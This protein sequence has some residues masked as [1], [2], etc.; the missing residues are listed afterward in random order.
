MSSGLVGTTL[1][2]KFQI[3]KPLASGAAGDVY[4]AMHLGLGTRVAVKVLRPGIE[5]TAGIRRKRFLREARVAARLRSDHVVRVYD[6]VAPEEGPTYIVMELLR[7]ETL[8]DRLKRGGRFAPT[9]AVDFVLQAARP[10]A[11]MHDEGIVHR[12][13]KP[14]NL[15]LARDVDGKERIKL[16][17]FGVAAFQQPV[18]RAE[19]S[20]TFSQAVL[21][22]PKYM[23]PEQV[24]ASSQVDARADVWALG[25]MLYRAAAGVAPFRGE[26]F[27]ALA[28][29]ILHH[30]P[31]PAS[32][33]VP[34]I[35]N[36]LDVLIAR[37]LERDRDARCP[38]VADI[39]KG[40]DQVKRDCG[41]DDEAIARAVDLDRGVAS[42]AVPAGAPAPTRGS[43]V[44]SRPVYQGVVEAPPRSKARLA[45][46][47]GLATVGLATAAY[48]AF[49]RAGTATATAPATSAPV[50]AAPATGSTGAPALRDASAST[51]AAPVGEA[52]L[53]DAIGSGDVQ[54]QS[55]AVDAL[56]LVASPKAAPLLYVAL[57]G[58][59]ELRVKAARALA[60][61]HLPDAAPK[62]RAAL[63]A[64]GD[65]VRVELAASLTAL[66]DKDALAIIKRATADAATRL[67]AAVA[68]ADA[69]DAADARP[70]LA[71]IIDT[72]P[73]GR[74]QWRRAAKG[75]VAISDDRGRLAL[76]GEL[77]Q[78]DGARAV[79]AAEILASTGDPK[80]HEM[81][82]RVVGDADHANRGDAALALAR[83]GDA[84][85]LD[86]VPVGLASSDAGDRKLAIATCAQLAAKA[87]GFAAQIRKLATDD[88][89]RTVRLAADAAAMEMR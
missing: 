79:A 11:E 17:D 20:L 27:A 32:E 36:S 57:H 38:S 62:V 35:G 7:G 48:F 58:G 88:P 19:S 59:P 8:A 78:H 82:A 29:K 89:D 49:G 33:H 54:L 18:A 70:I 45:I 52:A 30:T 61:L 13:V 22:T 37:C 6:V 34:A 71:D 50:A 1:D 44:E 24:R 65:R 69:G 16:L 83:L 75:L 85:A 12:D 74:E 14:S 23:A 47:V 66:G 40:L 80:A 9:E 87:G 63:D 26:G 72:T 53:R 67:V 81:L 77:A 73:A 51:G 76:A 55:Q 10:L 28:D 84:T 4:E 31:P 5:E 39:L 3:E 56:A 41:L 86:W 15:F 21:G 25:V 64:S 46:G 43:L 42:E 60:A 2:G 68:L